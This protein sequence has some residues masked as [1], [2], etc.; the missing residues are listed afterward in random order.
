MFPVQESLD[1]TC[2]NFIYDKIV[3]APCP[4]E[5]CIRKAKCSFNRPEKPGIGMAINLREIEGSLHK[6]KFKAEM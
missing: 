4:K 1:R 2:T 5:T 3:L 6:K